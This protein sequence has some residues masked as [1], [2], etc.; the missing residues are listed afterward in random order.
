MTFSSY[1][2]LEVCYPSNVTTGTTV[3]TG[4]TGTTG[5]TGTTVTTGTTGTAGTTGTGKIVHDV[6]KHRYHF[7]ST[8][9]HQTCWINFRKFENNNHCSCCS[10]LCGN[11]SCHYWN[12][13]VQTTQT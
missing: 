7:S 12:C 6:N 13:I 11:D 8:V 3:T 5:T 1:G 9:S 2:T 10:Y 4:A